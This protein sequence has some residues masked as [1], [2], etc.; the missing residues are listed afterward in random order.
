MMVG[1]VL[2]SAANAR[3]EKR[4]R[5]RIITPTSMLTGLPF[6]IQARSMVE[7]QLRRRGIRDER[8]LEAMQLVPR[9]EFVP[10]QFESA[11]YDDRP[12]PIG[13][14]ETISQPYIVAAMT[15]AARVAPGDKALEIGAGSGYQAA[16][17]AHLG[18]S[19]YAIEVNPGLA[20]TARERL[21]RLGYHHVEVIAGDGS[22][23]LADYAPYDVII[24]SAGTPSVSPI[25]LGQLAEG[26]RLVA[27]V[28]SLQYQELL[29]LW[30][31]GGE[32]VTR[33]LGAC[34]FV[35]LVGK[36]GWPELRNTADSKP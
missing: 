18:A 30:K 35:P 34:Q 10:A 16:I 9:H 31:H 6:D 32:I 23:G 22:E 20:K 7:T 24:V 1:A 36:G 33:N 17:L 21:V 28:G 27:P 4:R 11:A 19:V 25:L 5:E 29:Q 26:G 3:G 12:L 15:E 8:V 13:V 2:R 14:H